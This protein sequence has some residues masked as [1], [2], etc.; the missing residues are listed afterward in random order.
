M[1]FIDLEKTYGQVEDSSLSIS[2]VDFTAFGLLDLKASSL[3][4][5]KE[6][7]SKDF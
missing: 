3:F 1:T 2:D 4:A 7:L 5:F 6:E